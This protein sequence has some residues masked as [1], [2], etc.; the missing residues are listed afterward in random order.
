MLRRRS[1]TT[2]ALT[3]ALTSATKAATASVENVMPLPPANAISRAVLTF[4]YAGEVCV[5]VLHYRETGGGLGHNSVGLANALSAKWDVWIK[6]LVPDTC[7]LQSVFVSDLSAAPRVPEFATSTVPRSGS[8]TTPQMPNNVAV[9][10]TLRTP[11][12]GRSGR[13]RLY[14]VGIT[15]EMVIANT[16]DNTWRGSLVSGYNQFR[17]MTDG[18]TSATWEWVVLSYYTGGALRGTPV[19]NAVASC[20][21]DSIPD[22]MRKR[23]P[24]H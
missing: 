15:E 21:V 14:H 23:L 2:I 13:G 11:V 19:A 1:S 8:L 5:N 3:V 22:S 20:A 17:N 4:N 9:C 7:T 6:T 10:V 16:L 18:T 24:G 12:G